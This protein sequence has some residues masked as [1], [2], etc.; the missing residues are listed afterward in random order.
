MSKRIVLTF[1][2]AKMHF[3]NYQYKGFNF[4]NLAAIK[5]LFF[6]CFIN[7]KINDYYV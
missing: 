7:R 5:I 3:L 2:T 4:Y 1:L 6:K